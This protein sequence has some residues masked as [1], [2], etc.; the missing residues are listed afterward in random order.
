M[1]QHSRQQPVVMLDEPYQP[2]VVEAATVMLRMMDGSLRII[3]ATSLLDE[4]SEL[5]F[6]DKVV[7]LRQETL[8]LRPMTKVEDKSSLTTADECATFPSQVAA[9]EAVDEMLTLLANPRSWASLE[10]PVVPTSTI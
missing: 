4:G 10:T 3:P 6:Q 9:A 7:P 8:P 1:P 2:F 5:S